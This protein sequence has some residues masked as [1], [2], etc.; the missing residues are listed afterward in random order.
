LGIQRE[1]AI[2]PEVLVGLVWRVLINFEA[3]IA[4]PEGALLFALRF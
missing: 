1:S 3:S 2:V 4:A